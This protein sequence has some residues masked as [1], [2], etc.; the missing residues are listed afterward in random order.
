MILRATLPAFADNGATLAV[1]ACEG[2]IILR[3]S[4]CAGAPENTASLALIGVYEM[5]E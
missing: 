5:N 3:P 4:S 1:H 2:E